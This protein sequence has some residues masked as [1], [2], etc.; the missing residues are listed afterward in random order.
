[1]KVIDYR[2][3]TQKPKNGLTDSAMMDGS[4][5]LNESCSAFDLNDFSPSCNIEDTTPAEAAWTEDAGLVEDIA[6]IIKS[7]SKKTSGRALRYKKKADKAL[8][9]AVNSYMKEKVPSKALVF[10]RQHSYYKVRA[11]HMKGAHTQLMTLMDNVEQQQQRANKNVSLSTNNL[12]NDVS[13]KLRRIQGMVKKTPL[14]ADTDLKLLQELEAIVEQ[15]R[16]KQV[17]NNKPSSDDSISRP[18]LGRAA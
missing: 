7:M 11:K 14:S 9:G 16:Q 8:A 6:L 4:F 10:M 3:P 5:S 17:A 12:S 13:E 2:S 18:V 1:M 15:Q